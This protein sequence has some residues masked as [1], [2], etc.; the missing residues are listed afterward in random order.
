MDGAFAA[1][2][3]L[4]TV[5]KEGLGA[6]FVGAFG[7]DEVSKVLGVPKELKPRVI[8][9]IGYPTEKPEKLER[10]TLGKRLHRE[11]W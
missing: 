6:C 9:P 3:I 11:V 1:M 5:V 2:I 4:L 7:D 8:I 10:I